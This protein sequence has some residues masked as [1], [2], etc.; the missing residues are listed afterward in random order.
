MID[1]YRIFWKL[2]S[3]DWQNLKIPDSMS[4]QYV[5]IHFSSTAKSLQISNNEKIK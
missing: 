2:R 1:L 4:V 3:K 5:E